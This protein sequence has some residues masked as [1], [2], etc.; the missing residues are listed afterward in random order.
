MNGFVAIA[1]A[2][3]AFTGIGAG[4]GISIATGKASEAIS[5]QPEASGKIMSVTLLGT[6]LSEATAIYGFVIALILLLMKWAA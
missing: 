6:A 5:R 2:I 3:A 1:A 4:I